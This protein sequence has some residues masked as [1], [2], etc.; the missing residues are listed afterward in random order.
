M[1][2][3]TALL[4]IIMPWI[5]GFSV[6]KPLLKQR[7]G[8]RSLAWGVGYPVG[9]FLVTV[10]IHVCDVWARPLDVME[11]LAV[12]AVIALPLLLMP[13]RRCSMEEQRF[14]K[15][16]A[17]IVYFVVFVLSL[18]LLYRWALL[19]LELLDGKGFDIDPHFAHVGE[20]RGG[21]ASLARCCYRERVGIIWR[22]ALFRCAVVGGLFGCLCFVECAVVDTKCDNACRELLDGLGTIVFDVACRYFARLSRVAHAA[23]YRCFDYARLA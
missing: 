12:Q 23:C 16:S 20:S 7:Y 2:I 3:I 22:I 11:L 1:T 18:A 5:L 15:A 9:W 10:L 13:A 17:N 21:G 6:V 19:A 8:Y 14:E 4:A